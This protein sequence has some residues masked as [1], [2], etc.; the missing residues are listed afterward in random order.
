VLYVPLYAFGV[1]QIRSL[2]WIVSI[3]GLGMIVAPL[4]MP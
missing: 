1:Q 3:A 2:V 4:V